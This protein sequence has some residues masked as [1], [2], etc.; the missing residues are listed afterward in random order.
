MRSG[1]AID[2]HMRS[3]KTR[4]S[5]DRTIR[6][7]YLLRVDNAFAEKGVKV[8]G[9]AITTVGKAVDALNAG[10]IECPEGFCLILSSSSKAHYLLYENGKKDLALEILSGIDWKEARESATVEKS[11]RTAPISPRSSQTPE[12]RT[13]AVSPLRSSD[14]RRKTRDEE[15]QQR[16]QQDWRAIGAK[17]R[18]ALEEAEAAAAPRK[19][20]PP[21]NSGPSAPPPGASPTS[22]SRSTRTSQGQGQGQGHKDPSQGQSQGQSNNASTSTSTNDNFQVGDRTF[23]LMGVIGRGAFGVVQKGIDRQTDQVAAIKFMSAKNAQAFDTALFEADLLRQLTAAL[24]GKARSQVPVYFGHNIVREAN[25]GAVHLAMSFIP[26]VVVDQWL[27]GISDAQHKRVNVQELVY[28]KLPGGRQHTLDTEISSHVT[29]QLVEQAAN[30]MGV[31]EHIA[32]HRDVSS[33]NVLLNFDATGHPNFALIDFGLA[34]KAKTWAEQWNSS[35]LAGDPRYWTPAAWMAFAF[36]FGFVENHENKGHVRQYLKRMDHYSVGVLGLEL[37]FALWEAP[38]VDTEKSRP[39]KEVRSAWCEFW[40][41][42]VRLFQMFHLKG[43][44]A[45]REY[46]TTN[47]DAGVFAMLRQLVKLKDRLRAIPP[48]HAQSGLMLAL[49]DLIDEAGTCTWKSLHS[50]LRGDL[51]SAVVSARRTDRIARPPPTVRNAASTPTTSTPTGTAP[52][53][54]TEKLSQTMPAPPP[55]PHSF[56]EGSLPCGK[57]DSR[58]QTLGAT[59]I[60][61]SQSLQSVHCHVRSSSPPLQRNGQPQHGQNIAA[62]PTAGVSPRP[63]PIVAVHS[64]RS[65]GGAPPPVHSADLNKSGSSQFSI[66]RCSMGSPHGAGHSTPGGAGNGWGMSRLS[67]S[68]PRPS[69]QP[70]HQ[71]RGSGSGSSSQ[72]HLHQHQEHHHHQQQHLQQP[73]MS[74]PMGG[75]MMTSTNSG[76]SN[77]SDTAY[78]TLRGPAQPPDNKVLGTRPSNV[79]RMV[80]GGLAQQARVVLPNNQMVTPGGHV[81][82]CGVTWQQHHQQQQQQ[83]QYHQQRLHALHFHPTIP[84]GPTVSAPLSSLSPPSAR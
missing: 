76:M 34:V 39:L 18:K 78:E 21:T 32:F 38:Q 64:V 80:V 9:E 27:Y 31:L 69:Q 68:G 24:D 23:K 73:H 17:M 10:A 81:G 22:G 13:P 26:G 16:E 14:A 67:G 37:F 1:S 35:N 25:G 33:H 46:L 65:A 82:S 51:G 28:G 71:A 84:C 58:R 5:S 79:Q 66:A 61:N 19:S 56:P 15:Q 8:L 44:I 12:V 55:P 62:V 63:W 45:T 4:W 59:P 53:S 49:A 41:S 20:Q 6:L 57:T 60:T 75:G 83:Q 42:T 47:L 29:R 70:P 52:P 30:V 2:P 74:T 11:A 48:T 43:P 36:G 7:G 72:Q 3:S 54:P 50:M 77:R 40:E